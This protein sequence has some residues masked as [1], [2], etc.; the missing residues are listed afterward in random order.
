M[1]TYFDLLNLYN[2]QKFLQSLLNYYIDINSP[3]FAICQH[4]KG[5]EF[6]F[7]YCSYTVSPL[8]SVSK[9][10]KCITYM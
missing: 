6:F 9:N 4:K 2:H 1:L 3:I 10:Y 5:F 7:I 8:L